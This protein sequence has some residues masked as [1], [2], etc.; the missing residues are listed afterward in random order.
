MK[1]HLKTVLIASLV[2]VLFGTL[3]GSKFYGIIYRSNVVLEGDSQI[4]HIPSGANFQELKDSLTPFLKNKESFDWVSEKK[5]FKN[6]VKAGRYRIENGFTNNQLVNLLRSGNQEPV[7]VVINNIRSVNDLAAVLASKLEG[8]SLDFLT[9]FTNSKFLERKALNEFSLLSVFIP[10]TYQFFWN[11][12]PEK[13]FERLKNESDA[14]WEKRESG[15]ERVAM[16][17]LELITLASIVESETPKKDEMPTVAG[18]YI[19]RL[20]RNMKLESD[21]TVIYAI[22]KDNP[23]EDIRRV[24]YKHLEYESPYNTYIHKGLPPGPILV[25]SIVAIDAVLN[26]QKHN[27]IFMTAEPERPGYHNFA[28]TL[29]EHTRNA[30]KYHAWVKRVQMTD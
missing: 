2:L 15:L 30:R 9:V 29:G 23:S 3:L 22:E 24:L 1:K 20:E 28:E 12:S 25:P 13:A 18:L 8:D 10:N 4:I 19:N 11:T 7:N 26:Y 27:Y 17:K 5:N 6:N 21:P 14:F 16:T